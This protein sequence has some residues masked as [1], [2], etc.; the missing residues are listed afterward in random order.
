MEDVWF[1][2]WPGFESCLGDE[3]SSLKKTIDAHE[4]IWAELRLDCVCDEDMGRLIEVRDRLQRD[5][6]FLN[7]DIVSFDKD[8]SRH[9]EKSIRL[10]D[11]EL[12]RK[13]L[14]SDKSKK[15]AKISK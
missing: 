15:K 9:T 8:V 13:R 10:R 11:T 3:I 14:H 5:I 1:E 2:G 4:K 12:K 6:G 7:K